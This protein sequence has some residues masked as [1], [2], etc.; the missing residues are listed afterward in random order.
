MQVSREGIPTALLS[1]PLR[2][3][4]TT[5]EVVSIQDMERTGRLLASFLEGLDEALAQELGLMG[6]G[7]GDAT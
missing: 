2:S 5:V 6:G 3:M 1:I 7:T 4:H